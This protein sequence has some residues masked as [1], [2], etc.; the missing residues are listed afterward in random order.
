MIRMSRSAWNNVIVFGV[1]AL[2]LLFYI[3]PNQMAKFRD[4]NAQTLVPSN[5]TIVQIRFPRIVLERHGPNWRLHPAPTAGSNGNWSPTSRSGI[6]SNNS[7]F[8][9][10]IQKKPMHCARSHCVADYFFNSLWRIIVK[11]VSC[12]NYQKLKCRAWELVH[13]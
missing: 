8:L 5:A 12:L 6:C 1:L 3:A 10:F 4:Q 11:R 9:K 13:I 2:F 7:G